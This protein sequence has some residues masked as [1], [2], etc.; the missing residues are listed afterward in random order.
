MLAVQ[1]FTKEEADGMELAERFAGELTKEAD[2]GLTVI[3]PA[4]A[5]VAKI[6]DVY[7]TVLY[8]K[9]QNKRVLI[10]AKDTIE[11]LMKEQEQGGRMV[12]FDFDPVNP[13]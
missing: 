5:S 2:H 12:Q 11:E 9:H 8:V 10:A 3:G 1:V 13:F 4:A 7:R 6:S